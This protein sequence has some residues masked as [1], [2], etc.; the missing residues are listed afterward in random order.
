MKES[1]I[2]NFKS[3]FNSQQIDLK[4]CCIKVTK[5]SEITAAELVNIFNIFNEY[6]FIIL[7][8]EPLE[9]PKENLLS[10]SR[11]FGNINKSHNRANAEGITIVKAIPGY[12]KY[13]GT[14]NKEHLLHTDGPFEKHPP[15]IFALQCEVA[16][17]KG[18]FSKIVRAIDIYEHLTDLYPSH[19]VTLFQP[20]V[21]AIGRDDRFAQRAIFE[22][23]NDRVFIFFRMEDKVTEI[24][25]QPEA[26]DAFKLIKEFVNNPKN[27]I[28][29]KLKP[30]QILLAD[31]RAILHGRSAFSENEPRL[32]NRVW[33][34]G[35]SIYAS[36]L[37]IGFTPR[38]LKGKR[39]L[40]LVRSHIPKPISHIDNEWTLDSFQYRDNSLRSDQHR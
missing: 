16:A 34:D 3:N 12:E 33:F 40:N 1:S 19:L 36:R 6:N 21:F 38:S 5:V 8:C 23:I 27:Q 11:L 31:N 17:K 14:T 10:L 9:K 2:L 22:I 28:T 24:K 20:D 18:G 37:K 25:I 32:L 15:E 26:I 29:F 13:I 39:F 4:K 35:Q 30:H 7:E